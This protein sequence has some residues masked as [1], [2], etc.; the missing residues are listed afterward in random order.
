MKLE[1]YSPTFRNILLSK[2]EIT[3]TE[4]GIYI[5][6]TEFI[7]EGNPKEYIAVKTGADCTV[8]KEGDKVKLMRGMIPD[9][10]DLSVDG[11]RQEY[12]QIPEQ[13]IIGY[14]RIVV[15]STMEDFTTKEPEFHVEVA[16]GL[17]E[18]DY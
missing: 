16:N 7:T 12:F 13:Q 14:E 8:I 4:G 17:T 15:P 6:S 3:K 5:P 11:K 2:V 1:N 18:A 10:F 9:N